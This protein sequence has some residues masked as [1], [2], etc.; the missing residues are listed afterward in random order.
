TYAGGKIY[1]PGTMNDIKSDKNNWSAIYSPKGGGAGGAAYAWNINSCKSPIKWSGSTKGIAK[2]GG[3]IN[4]AKHM[5]GFIKNYNKPKPFFIACGIFRPHLPWNCPKEFFDL[6]DLS[7]I[8]VPPPGYKKG[9]VGSCEHQKIVNSGKWDDAVRAYLACIS[10]VDY[11]VGVLLDALKA[12]GKANNT[13]VVFMGDHGWHLGEKSMWKKSSTWEHANHTTLIIYDPSAKGN[14]QVCQK[15]VGLQDIYPTLVEL[16]DLPYNNKV[17]GN[18]LEPLLDNPHIKSWSTPV[19]SKFRDTEYLRTNQWKFVE[20]GAKSELYNSIED[21]NEHNNLYGKAQYNT[22]VTELRAEMKR[23]RKIGQ[24]IVNG[25]GNCSNGPS[26]NITDLSAE[27]TN[28]ST[29]VLTWTK[30]NCAT[31]YEVYRKI[32]SSANF[33]KVGTVTGKSY[34]DD[35]LALSKAYTY[36]VKPAYGNKKKSSNQVQVTTPSSCGTGCATPGKTTISKTDAT[37]GSNNGK[38]TFTFKDDP[39]RTNIAFSIDGGINYTKV[40]DDIGSYSFTNLAQGNYNCWVQWGNGDCNTDLGTIKISCTS[41]TKAPVAKAGADQTVTD[42]NGN[43]VE[44]ITLDGSKSFDTDG[45]ITNYSWTSGGTQLATGVSSKVL[46]AIGTHKITLTVTDNDGLTGSDDVTITVKTGSQDVTP[47]TVPTGLKVTKVGQNMVKLSWNE[48][49][50]S[51]SGVAGYRVYE[52]GVLVADV[53]LLSATI[54]ELTC[55]TSYFFSVSAYD[56]E[57]NES[58]A[59]AEVPATTSSCSSQPVTVSL[60]PINDAFLQGKK[61][62]NLNLIRIEPKKRTGYLMF[63]LSSVNGTITSAKL[64]LKCA[65]DAGKGNIKINLGTSNNWTEKKLTSKNKPGM[66]TQLASL[67]KAYKIG[68]VYTWNLNTASLKGGGKVSLIVTQVSGND[69]AFGSEENAAK[70]VLEIT[71]SGRPKMTES[72]HEITSLEIFPNPT[73]GIFNIS[74]I[75]HEKASIK[76]INITG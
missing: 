50:D 68:S 65:A 11:N 28:C 74:L 70:P 36:L 37:C 45:T 1:H 20:K 14:G 49:Y 18:N 48:S 41:V 33:T 58:D 10:Y 4:L 12:S 69:V 39:V 59:S 40:K 57:G 60:S 54:I 2:G 56:N 22:V 51:E 35:A 72:T 30:V 9:G 21:I 17:E 34:T 53:A 32:T 73:D 64:K 67:N 52:N 19:L 5:A 7:K 29:A 75:G 55:E 3:D 15:V 43:G 25:G 13:I 44:T 46:L 76:I 38:I 61:G 8:T 31:S 63:D 47:P 42:L 16:C 24:D 62:Y 66:G 71:Y 6:Y 26:S 27:V 23:I